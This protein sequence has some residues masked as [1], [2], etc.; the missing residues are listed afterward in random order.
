M[1]ED[2]EIRERIEH[3][4]GETHRELQEYLGGVAESLRSLPPLDTGLRPFTAEERDSISRIVMSIISEVPLLTRR[5]A[6]PS[7]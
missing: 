5:S 6:T 3:L 2:E 1:N 4:A 7:Q